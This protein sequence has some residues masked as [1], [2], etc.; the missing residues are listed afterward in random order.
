MTHYHALGA[1]AERRG[2]LALATPG[3]H[4]H[5]LTVAILLGAHPSGYA[6]TRAAYEGAFARVGPDDFFSLRR[7]IG[8]AMAAGFTPESAL[9]VRGEDGQWTAR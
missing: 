1:Y 7:G 9:Q 4:A 5:L 8:G 2:G 6:E 3:R